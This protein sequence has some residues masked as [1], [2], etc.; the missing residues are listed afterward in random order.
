MNF[1]AGERSERIAKAIRADM[2]AETSSLSEQVSALVRMV[3]R[4]ETRVDQLEHDR[5]DGS[6]Q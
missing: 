6:M 4:L 1:S 5:G 3:R 2:Q